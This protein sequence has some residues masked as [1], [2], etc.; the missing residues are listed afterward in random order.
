[1]EETCQSGEKP[2]AGRFFHK[3]ARTI[4]STKNSTPGQSYLVHHCM[5]RNMIGVSKG[6]FSL[7]P[8][9]LMSHMM[10]ML[11]A[12]TVL[13]GIHMTGPAMQTTETDMAGSHGNGA[14]LTLIIQTQLS[15]LPGVP[16]PGTPD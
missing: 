2:T 8:L 6:H 4:L 10:S 7:V 11:P 3:E 1:M 5:N 15:R 16:A 12:E 9:L 14:H 13:P